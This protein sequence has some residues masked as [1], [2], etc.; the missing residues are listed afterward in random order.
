MEAT[1]EMKKKSNSYFIKT[2]LKNEKRNDKALEN[3]GTDRPEV[4]V[5]IL[6]YFLLRAQNFSP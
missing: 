5:I 2:K 4:L 3:M 1:L 6:G